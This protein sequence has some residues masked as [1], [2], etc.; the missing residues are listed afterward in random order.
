MLMSYSKRGRYKSRN[1]TEWNQLGCAPPL[2]IALL[3]FETLFDLLV[4]CLHQVIAL[5]NC[6]TV[7]IIQCRST[8]ATLYLTLSV[9]LLTTYFGVLI[10]QRSGYSSGSGW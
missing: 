10:N 2:K 9:T 7:N 4:E 5:L 1:G 3:S 8:R 6:F